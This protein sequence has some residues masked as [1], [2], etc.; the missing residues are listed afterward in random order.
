MTR[1]PRD[2]RGLGRVLCWLADHRTAAHGVLML[3]VGI[4]ALL[5]WL[6]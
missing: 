2:P 6:P 4:Y 1:T 5:L 3:L